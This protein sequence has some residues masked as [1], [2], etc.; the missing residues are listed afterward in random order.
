MN[1]NQ[2]RV[3]VGI[4]AIHILVGIILPSIG[5]LYINMTFIGEESLLYSF[6]LG[7]LIVAS[8]IYFWSYNRPINSE[9][10]TE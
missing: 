6:C 9:D 7:L 10:E 3:L 4:K 8:I 1:E 2:D 5:I